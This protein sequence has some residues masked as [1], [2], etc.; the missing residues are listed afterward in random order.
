[1]ELQKILLMQQSTVKKNKIKLITLS[2]FKNHNPLSKLGDVN[3]HV[4]SNSYNF[5]EMSHHIIL[6]SIVD[7]FAQQL[8]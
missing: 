5:V 1:M 8:L 7:I 6:V 2:G 3:I 4:R